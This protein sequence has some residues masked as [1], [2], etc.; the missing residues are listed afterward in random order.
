MSRT[1]ARAKLRRTPAKTID[2]AS[3]SVAQ[4]RLP[5][6]VGTHACAER[7]PALAGR[8]PGYRP[9]HQPGLFWRSPTLLRVAAPARRNDIVPSV[10]TPLRTR[11]DV[12]DVLSGPAAVLTSKAI[13]QEDG[14][15]IERHPTVH[16]HLHVPAQLDHGRGRHRDVL[17]VP[18]AAVRLDH[19]RPLM[20]DEDDRPSC[21][22]D[23][24]RLVGGVEHQ[25]SRHAG[26]RTSPF[27]AVLRP[28]SSPA[29]PLAPLQVGND[30]AFVDRATR[31]AVGGPDPPGEVGGVRQRE[32]RRRSPPV[33]SCQRRQGANRLRP[34]RRTPG[35][36]TCNSQHWNRT[37]TGAV[38]PHEAARPPDHRHRELAV[39]AL[40]VS[41]SLPDEG[42]RQ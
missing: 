22:D 26:Q 9:Q 14:T 20:E 28:E 11:H 17:G 5:R 34:Q 15:A 18:H 16:S 10:T 13:A 35:D 19:L 25:C 8:R 38:V 40:I 39:V 2:R 6:R 29:L 33:P 31:V 41:T 4:V 1:S 37:H 21:R 7:H 42:A 12:I 23:G 24:E 27:P 32:E 30:V 3:A 36:R